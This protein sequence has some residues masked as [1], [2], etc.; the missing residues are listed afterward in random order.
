MNRPSEFEPRRDDQKSVQIQVLAN[1]EVWLDN[2]LVDVRAVPFSRKRGFSKG[3]TERIIATVIEEAPDAPAALETFVR[4]NLIPSREE[5]TVDGAGMS[6][7]NQLAVFEMLEPIHQQ[8]RL[9]LARG[10]AEG[11]FRSDL[12][13]EAVS[14]VMFHMIGSGRR[15]VHMGRDPD[16]SAETIAT[17]MVRGVGA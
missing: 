11:T 10:V 3:E 4:G 16:V 14:E 1:G 17:V 15:L 9:I 2:R 7:E 8:L 12:D 5:I 13:P 6:P